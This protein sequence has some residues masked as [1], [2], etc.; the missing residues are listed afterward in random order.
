MS[1]GRCPTV[2]WEKIM[3]CQ[4]RCGVWVVT[5]QLLLR[6]LWIRFYFLITVWKVNH[7]MVDLKYKLG[8]KLSDT[9]YKNA[10]KWDHDDLENISLATCSNQNDEPLS[11]A[12]KP[13]STLDWCNVYF[14]I[15]PEFSKGNVIP[16][17]LNF[18]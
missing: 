4:H 16:I 12:S 10:R 1:S 14:C 5:H 13:C 11:H 17:D 3:S 18:G 2:V 9:P 15:A 7:K 6:T 8:I